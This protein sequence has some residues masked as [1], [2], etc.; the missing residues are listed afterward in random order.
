MTIFTALFLYIGIMA[1]VYHFLVLGLVVGQNLGMPSWKA[2]SG[3]VV[4][5]ML[6]RNVTKKVRTLVWR[7]W[8]SICILV[9]SIL[10]LIGVD[11][12]WFNN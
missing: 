11:Q 6:F 2:Y 7:W 1:V 12:G 3:A 9:I 10:L 8:F 5:A 4:K